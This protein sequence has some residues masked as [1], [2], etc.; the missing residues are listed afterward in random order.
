MKRFASL[1]LAL[2]MICSLSVTAFAQTPEPA[3][4]GTSAS[5]DENMY[6]G[7]TPRTAQAK[8]FTIPG[9]QGT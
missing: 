7:I 6:T 5:A 9:G 8:P 2:I 1:V 4:G 3:T